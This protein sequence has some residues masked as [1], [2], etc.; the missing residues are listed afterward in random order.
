MPHRTLDRHCHMGQTFPSGAL[1]S[2]FFRYD[3]SRMGRTAFLKSMHRHG[4]NFTT[5]IFVAHISEQFRNTSAHISEVCAYI[6][7][8]FFATKGNRRFCS[9]DSYIGSLLIYRK[10]LLTKITE[11]DRNPRTNKKFSLC[12]SIIAQENFCN[13]ASSLEMKM[14]KISF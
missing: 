1:G 4:L 11:H 12:S 8:N 10:F 3:M 2:A 13:L 9:N 6:G 7:S 5:K 14:K